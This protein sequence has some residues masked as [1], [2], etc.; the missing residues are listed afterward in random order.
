M[1]IMRNSPECARARAAVSISGAATLICK[2]VAIS[3][4][5]WISAGP[6]GP[7]VPALLMSSTQSASRLNCCNVP[8]SSQVRSAS[9]LPKSS[10]AS[11]SSAGKRDMRSGLP[12][13]A[14]PSTGMLRASSWAV[15]AAPKPREWPVTIARIIGCMSCFPFKNP[16]AMDYGEHDARVLSSC[17]CPR[18]DGSAQAGRSSGVVLND[19][20]RLLENESSPNGEFF[21]WFVEGFSIISVCLCPAF[22]AL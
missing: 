18:S 7:S 22:I 10:S 8:P 3:C 21:Q 9:T 13:R 6:I 4:N 11:C 12:C 2:V 5:G 17:L 20:I 15:M 1:W 19:G 16:S 14:Q